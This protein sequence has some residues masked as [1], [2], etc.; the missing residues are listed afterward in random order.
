[1]ILYYDGYRV[2]SIHYNPLCFKNKSIQYNYFERDK[3]H[4][5]PHVI[6]NWF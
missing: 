6:F 1:M 2:I 3:P 4:E 5:Y